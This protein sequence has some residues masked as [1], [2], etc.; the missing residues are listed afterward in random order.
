M[1]AF[2]E[3]VVKYDRMFD[4][5]KVKIVKEKYIVKANDYNDAVIRLMDKL[6]V[7]HCGA[8]PMEVLSVKRTNY[9]AY[10]NHKESEK[11]F[12]VKIN[13]YDESFY[14]KIGQQSHLIQCDSTEQASEIA[15]EYLL[16]FLTAHEIQSITQKKY[17]DVYEYVDPATVLGKHEYKPSDNSNTTIE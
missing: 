9:T 7:Y 15:N 3:V 13:I 4:D 10:I 14:K 16:S 1:K 8:Y 12:L 6:I 11:Y 2:Y 17:A 5:G